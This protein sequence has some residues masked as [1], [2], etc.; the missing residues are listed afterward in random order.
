MFYLVDCIYRRYG[1]RSLTEVQGILHITP[2]L[3]LSILFMTIFYA[4]LPGT[5]KFISEF[6][7][8]SGLI[9][10]SSITCFLLMFIANVCG[11]IGFSKC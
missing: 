8:F 6:Y 11:L 7:I 5:I 2:N 1:S 3:G 4:G 9:E 10:V